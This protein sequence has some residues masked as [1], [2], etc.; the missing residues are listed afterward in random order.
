MPSKP[1]TQSP[2]WISSSKQDL[3]ISAE[4]SMSLALGRG[5]N[6]VLTLGSVNPVSAL[7]ARWLWDYRYL[8]YSTWSRLWGCGEIDAVDS[9][10]EGPSWPPGVTALST[11]DSSLLPLLG[12][13]PAAGGSTQHCPPS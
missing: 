7:Q 8:V 2:T 10:L 11:H 6:S 9:D 4:E 5:I 13:H 12:H 3:S 1:S